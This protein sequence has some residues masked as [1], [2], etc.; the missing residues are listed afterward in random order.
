MLMHFSQLYFNTGFTAWRL[1]SF[2]IIIII[3]IAFI[4]QQ[5]FGYLDYFFIEDS[6]QFMSGYQQ[7]FDPLIA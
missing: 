3:V 1:A 7:N 2:F 4:H 5:G 6:W